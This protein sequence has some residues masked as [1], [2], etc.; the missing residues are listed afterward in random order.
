MVV[1]AQRSSA[2]PIV[3]N[4]NL[5]L[6]KYR[7]AA[8]IPLHSFTP[9]FKGV[10]RRWHFAVLYNRDARL[11]RR[12]MAL[13]NVEKE[14]TVGD[15]APYTVNAATDYTAPAHAERRGLYHVLIE[16]RQDLIADEAG[17][18]QWAARPARLLPL[19]YQQLAPAADHRNLATAIPNLASNIVLL[20][21]VLALTKEGRI[22]RRSAV[23]DLALNAIGISSAE[24][25]NE[26]SN[27]SIRL[28]FT[29]PK[30]DA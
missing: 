20:A 2:C 23:H 14:L 4:S 7:A 21:P 16:I 1:F 10:A 17:Q 27:L 22:A 25:G 5:C 24:P 13:L 9:V 8:L 6:V 15:N 29:R 28:C 26:R 11:A 3:A 19:A 30:N 18:R 12:L